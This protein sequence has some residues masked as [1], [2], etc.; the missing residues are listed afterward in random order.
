MF[1]I[2][3]FLSPAQ[4][5]SVDHAAMA[6]RR[7]R[8]VCVVGAAVLALAAML[9]AETLVPAAG[10]MDVVFVHGFGGPNEDEKRFVQLL[11][12]ELDKVGAS[13]FGQV[14]AAAADHRPFGLL[15]G[16]ICGGELPGWQGPPQQLLGKGLC[17][18]MGPYANRGR[19]AKKCVQVPTMLVH[20]DCETDEGGSAPWRVKQWTETERFAVCYFPE[21][22]QQMS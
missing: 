9:G 8:T 17:M 22:H 7:R 11:R 1:T 2:N 14:D 12:E 3:W 18:A 10:P 13:G 19:D 4:V 20:G 21:G 6:Q 15:S 5:T 16:R